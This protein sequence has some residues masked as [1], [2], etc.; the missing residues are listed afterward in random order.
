MLL[1]EFVSTTVALRSCTL[2]ATGLQD[3]HWCVLVCVK[4][5]GV[6]WWIDA[7]RVVWFIVPL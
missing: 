3:M 1:P 5:G 6:W 2:Q 7:L 4:G